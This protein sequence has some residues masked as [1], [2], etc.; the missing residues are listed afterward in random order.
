M[1]SFNILA[2]DMATTTGYAILA[3]GVMTSGS[4]CFTKQT[5]T[6]TRAAAHVGA[7]HAMFDNWLTE[8]LHG[9]RYD[10]IVFEMAGFFKSAA[11]VQVCVGFRGIL[12]CHAA[13]H[14]IPLYSYSP[15]A[16]KKFWTGKGTAK[17]PDM[18]AKTKQEYPDLDITDDNECDAIAL[19]RM[20]LAK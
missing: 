17:K 8:M 12:L 7:S 19:L 10:E 16:I 6:K 15:S 9:P 11:A 4:Q 13:K 20:H 3:S 1:K 18:I 14:N 5:A 2:L